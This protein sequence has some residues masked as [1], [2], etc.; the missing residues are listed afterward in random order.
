MCV[1]QWCLD[2]HVC[3]DVEPKS[4]ISGIVNGKSYTVIVDS[5]SIYSFIFSLAKK[6]RLL[7]GKERTETVTIYMW[8]AK[9]TVNLRVQ[10]HRYDG[11]LGGKCDGPHPL[12]HVV[13]ED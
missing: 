5:G 6:L 3:L 7:R 9:K 11:H 1:E 4:N 10:D 12:Q 13:Q 2:K 8:D